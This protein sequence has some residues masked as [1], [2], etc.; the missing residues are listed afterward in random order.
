M[1]AIV[2]FV[3]GLLVASGIA[4]Y[5]MRKSE[6]AEPAPPQVTSV[7]I[8]APQETAAPAPEPAVQP[9][10]REERPVAA[11]RPTPMPV[12]KK[13]PE[14]KK[15]AAAPPPKEPVAEIAKSTH[16]PA[17]TGAAKSESAAEPA[18]PAPPAPPEP[19]P[20]TPHTATLPAGTLLTVRLSESLSS[21]R[22][23][24]GEAFTAVLDK[25]LIADGFV[26]AERGSR[27]E[28]RIVESRQAGRVKG[29]SN[30][31]IELV[32]FKTADGQSIKITTETFEKAGESSVKGDAAK[33]GV[34]AGIGAAI[35]AIAG[36]GRGAGIGA[37]VGGA[38]GTGGVLATRGKAAT[39]PV[40]TRVT[41]KIKEP[42][43]VTEK[44]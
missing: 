14:P 22:N 27:V 10:P 13:R 26:L 20:Y 40:E 32:G 18:P 2:A 16:P 30:L 19:P 15:E 9:A 23:Q 31:A 34:A 33:V 29:L 37:A 41:F 35:G 36:G 25:P 6:P 43:K 42:V 7:P 3:A 39:L 12:K 21:D 44:I 8:P 38:A 17:D 1:K 11:V 24:P 5:S 4:Y 28:G